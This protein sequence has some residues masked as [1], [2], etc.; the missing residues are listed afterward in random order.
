MQERFAKHGISG[1]ARFS[2]V[3]GERLDIPSRWQGTA[4]A[5]GCLHSNLAVVK[6]ARDSGWPSV[7][8][9]EDDVVFDEDLN[10]KLPRFM[11]QLPNDWDMVFFGGMH[12]DEPVRVREN[13]L[14]LTAS[15]STYAYAVRS[16]LYPAF[17]ETHVDSDQPIDIR[18]RVL[19]EKFNCYCFYPHLAWVDGGLSDTQGRPV[20]PWWL[21]ESLVLGGPTMARIQDRTLV[22]IVHRDDPRQDLARRNLIYAVNAY[23]R[24]LNGATIAVVEAGRTRSVSLPSAVNGCAHIAIAAEVPVSRGRCFNEA[25]R[26][27]GA[28]KDFYVFVDRDVVPTW[29]AKAHLLMCREYDVASCFRS[30]IDLTEAD[31]ARLVNVAPMD[32]SS[33]IPRPR[34]TAC[35]EC[36]TFT[37]GAFHGMGGWDD[38]AANDD[39]EEQQSCRTR[40]LL[41]VFDSPGLGVRLFS[42]GNA[43]SARQ[44][45]TS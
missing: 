17:L 32:G 4:G 29:D 33:Y 2:A 23:R 36:C 37:K 40:Q 6:H 26:K 22:V 30:L 16:T 35:A 12:R 9:F 10:S 7:L 24:L 5:Y 3:D 27:F 14:K 8:L 39:D 21:K 25:V 45:G 1:V 43:M 44:S 41:S 13:V 19:Q 28:S 15:T 31:S 42:D 34:R 18:N 11:A 38:T 20:V